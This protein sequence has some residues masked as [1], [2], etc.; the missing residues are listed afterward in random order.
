M[1][2]EEWRDIKGYEGLYQISSEGRVKSLPRNG[3][4]KNERIL[5][6]SAHHTGYIVVSLHKNNIG[7]THIVHLLE[8]EAFY[9]PIPEGMQVNHI[10]ERKDDNRLE[11]LN[12]MTPK[13]N[14]NWGTRTERMRNKRK[15]KMGKPIIQYDLDGTYINE[16]PSIRDIKRQLGYNST[17]IIG[18]CKGKPK[19][20]TAYGYIWRY[21]V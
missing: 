4:I 18:C 5:K 13:E 19:F 12:L 8:W 9:G 10:N 16:Y 21:A 2:M 14:C 11:N 3:T 17:G 7:K 6:L 20:K 1:D 15:N